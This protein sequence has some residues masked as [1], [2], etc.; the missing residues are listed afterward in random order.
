MNNAR[1]SMIRST[2]IGF[3]SIA[4]I[5]N[6]TGCSTLPRNALPLD[7][8]DQAEP[9]RM[10]N[11]RAPGGSVSPPMQ[12]DIV[13]SLEQEVPGFLSVLQKQ[14]SGQ[15]SSSLPVSVPGR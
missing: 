15:D 4:V 13:A 1:L 5:L 10:S 14:A 2:L 6:I 3:I 12:A 7:K 8:P 9:L 11:V